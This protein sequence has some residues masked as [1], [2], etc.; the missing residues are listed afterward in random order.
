MS[1]IRKVVDETPEDPRALVAYSEFYITNVCNLACTNCNRF[2]DHDFRGWQRWSDYAEQYQQWSKRVKLQKITILGGEPLLNPTICDWVD[3]INQ[4]WNKPVQIL[5]NGTR[6]NQVPDLYDRISKFGQAPKREPRNWIGISLHNENDRERCFE[7]IRKFLRGNITYI[8][9]DDPRNVDNAFTRG[10]DHAFVDQHDMRICVWEYDSFYRAA[11]QKN[12]H[13]KFTL[14]NNDA[15]QAHQGC[16]FVMF[17]CYHFI[18]AKLYKCGPVALFPEFDQQ[19]PFDISE[20]DRILL[21][22]YSALG[23][24]EFETRGQ[25]FLSHIDDVIPQCKFCPTSADQR[26]DKLYAVSK[27]AGS[28]RQFE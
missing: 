22:S 14:F 18:R 28:T 24:D 12:Q 11:V 20:E 2:N 19:H 7:E 3:G 26:N 21:N 27:K 8:H 6:L 25:E 13:G 4:L 1:K 15:A 9:K 17:K 10:G 16:G 23:V 5:S